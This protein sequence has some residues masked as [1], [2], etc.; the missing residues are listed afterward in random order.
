MISSRGWRVKST[1]LRCVGVR[2]VSGVS[3]CVFCSAFYIPRIKIPVFLGTFFLLR[4]S[5]DE[6]IKT[7]KHLTI[8]CCA[9]LRDWPTHPSVP[10]YRRCCVDYMV[11]SYFKEKILEAVFLPTSHAFVSNSTMLHTQYSSKK[12][13]FVCGHYQSLTK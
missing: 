1:F 10:T 12:P 5:T 11:S 2:T 7:K 8:L 3:V 4:Y 13:S 9:F 6:L